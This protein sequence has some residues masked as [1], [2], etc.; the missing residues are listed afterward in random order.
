MSEILTA[1]QVR[2]KA[3]RDAIASLLAECTD[4]QR[5]LLNQIHDAAP[6]R[7]LANLPDYK[8]D[9]TYELVR[10][11]VIKNRQDA[12]SAPTSI[13]KCLRCDADLVPTDHDLIVACPRCKEEFA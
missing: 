8:V 10:R 7:G 1:A 13:G 6:W 5:A 12:A 9:E 4:K 11:T 2:T 3:V